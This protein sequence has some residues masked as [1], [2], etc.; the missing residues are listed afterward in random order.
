M[1]IKTV[2]RLGRMYY[3]SYDAGKENHSIGQEEL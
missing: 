2:A 1:T 3:N